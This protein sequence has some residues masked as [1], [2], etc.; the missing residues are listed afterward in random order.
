MKRIKTVVGILEEAGGYI[1]HKEI[2]VKKVMERINKSRGSAQN[3]INAA[4]EDNL[5]RIVPLE[6][7]GHGYRLPDYEVEVND[8]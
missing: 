6:K 5:I 3:A 7:K 2:L 1:D 8:D 4:C